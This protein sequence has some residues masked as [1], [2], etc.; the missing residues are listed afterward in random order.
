MKEREPLIVT[1][2][3]TLTLLLWLGFFVHR[4]PRFPGSLAGSLLGFLGGALMLVPL[5][6]TTVKRIPPLRRLCTR[7]IPMRSFL[8][9]H[10]YAGILG[11]I[12]ALLHTGHRFQS[13]L[14]VALTAMM[15]VVVVSGF[16]G[17]D[18]LIRVQQGRSGR[19]R[20]LDGLRSAYERTARALRSEAVNQPELRRLSRWR[21]ALAASA[22]LRSPESLA[23]EN[24][25]SPL[26]ALHLAESIADLEYA[27]R[28]HDV[29][30]RIFRVWLKAHLVISVVLYGL[31][32][33]HVWSGF[34]FG[35]R[36]LG[37]FRAS[38]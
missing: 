28:S 22:A 18:L 16:F 32:A 11:P 26:R 19:Q 34:Y 15:L 21:G 7:L 35:L 3:V 8:A 17:R 31:L 33:L 37:D 27:V 4:S 24:P 38:P 36:W 2:L 13:P 12:L 5:A 6:Y 20:E 25:T 14:G 29:L 30:R 23:L 10:I 9:W 1:G